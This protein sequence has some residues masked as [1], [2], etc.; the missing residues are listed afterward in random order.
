MTA[1]AFIAKSQEALRRFRHV[2]H[3]P[4]ADQPAEIISNPQTG[5]LALGCLK[6]KRLIALTV[7]EDFKP[8]VET[9]EGGP[10]PRFKIR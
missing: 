2:E 6:C 5:S 7:A 4:C 9:T 3:A 8:V 10:K 1:I